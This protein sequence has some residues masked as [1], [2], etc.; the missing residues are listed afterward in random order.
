MVS[1]LWPTYDVSPVPV[2]IIAGVPV[3]HASFIDELTDNDLLHV[4][5][6]YTLKKLKRLFPNIEQHKPR[7]IL[8]DH[9]ALPRKIFDDVEEYTIPAF[10]AQMAKIFTQS[11][12]G[13]DVKTQHAA[14]IMVNQYA[15]N[16]WTALKFAQIWNIDFDYTYNGMWRTAD[17][18]DLIPWL[19]NEHLGQSWND[20][21]KAAF[22]RP[23]ELPTKWIH[24]KFQVDMDSIGVRGYGGNY[25]T[26]HNGLNQLFSN[27]A[28]SLI[29]E[30]FPLIPT[31]ALTEKTVFAILGLTLPIWI[32][33]Q[34]SADCLKNLGFDIFEDIIDH[35]YQYEPN[36]IKRYWRAFE[37]NHR[38]LQD[39]KYAH[40]L[41]ISVKT[42][43]LH[44]RELL[45]SGQLE[46]ACSAIMH[47]WPI[48]IQS[49]ARPV[50]ADRF[51]LDLT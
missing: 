37:L 15:E 7:A 25:W 21:S 1:T 50:M 4:Y 22:I 3:H 30:S 33:Q 11:T 49:L 35:S 13:Q 23:M 20:Q 38:I 5:D 19:S 34:N 44:N 12:F 40:D 47:T 24:Y 31:P 27:S 18:G 26:W 43:L 8:N 16:R 14:N 42:R 48:E 6:A 36:N 2:D 46:R 28:V 10:G 17:L 45:L 29:T 32:A 41:R 51:M 39:A 9:N